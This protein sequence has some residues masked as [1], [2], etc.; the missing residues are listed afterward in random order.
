MQANQS[1]DATTLLEVGL[2]RP[3]LAWAEDMA[4]HEHHLSP[5]WRPDAHIAAFSKAGG[6]AAACL[7]S[8]AFSVASRFFCAASSAGSS[9]VAAPLLATELALDAE[10]AEAAIMVTPAV[11]TWQAS[12]RPM[13]KAPEP[14]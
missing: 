10:M 11:A 7:R 13:R 14:N 2:Y 9:A 3:L 5:P 8:N 1:P 4:L 6:A 12:R